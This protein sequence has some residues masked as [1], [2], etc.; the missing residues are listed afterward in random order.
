MHVWVM[1]RLVGLG[2]LAALWVAGAPLRAADYAGVDLRIPIAAQEGGSLEAVMVLPLGGGRHPLVI[3]SHGSPREARDRPGM[4]ARGMM[5]QLVAFARRGFVA[6][7]VLRRGYGTSVGPWAEGSGP[8]EKADYA[9]SA[10]A[11]AADIRTAIAFM[12]RRD[13]VDIT[14]IVAVGQ[15]A[16]GFATVALT[17]DPPSG[18]VAAISFAG[19]RGSRAP[20]SVCDE[21]ALVRAF[22]TFG[23]RS[24][25]PMLWIYT[26]NDRYFGPALAR[27]FRAAFQDSGGQVSFVAAPAFGSDGHALFSAPNGRDI[28]MPIV[29]AFLVRQGLHLPAVRPSTPSSLKPP[30]SLGA[31]GQAAFGTYLDSPGSK[32]FAV[33][34][35]GG[36][37]W[38]TGRVSALEARDGALANCARATGTICRLHA[39][40]D[41]YVVDP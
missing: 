38:R 25:V 37:G 28:W 12:T 6:V 2:G 19:G 41:A 17:A 31:A 10:R 22:G 3:L 26:E 32:A 24:H 1:F 21:D 16:G 23:R 33:S 27:R 13:D 35:T 20:D 8:C 18:L 15:S 4:S 11:G 29:E 36:Y 5:P 9:R 14:R 39:V 7:S 30:Q 34:A 40:D